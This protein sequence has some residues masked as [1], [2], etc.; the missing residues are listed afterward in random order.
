VSATLVVSTTEVVSAETFT[1][2]TA[3]LSV[4]EVSEVDALPQDVKPKIAAKPNTSTFFMFFLI[5]V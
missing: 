4:V 3:V 5:F 1:E 2:S